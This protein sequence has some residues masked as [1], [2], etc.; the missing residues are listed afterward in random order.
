MKKIYISPSDQTKNEYAAGGTT[1]AVQCREIA[2]LLAHSLE[3][4][5]FDAKT[6]IKDG[7]AARVK[8]S[9]DFGADLHVCIHTNAYD[10]KPGE[11]E[12]SGTRLFCYSIG[13]AGYK[14]CQAVMARLA[15]VTPG[16]SD[17][18]SARPE[19]Y[20]VRVPSAPTVYVEV[21]FHD[22]PD[23]ADWILAHKADIAEA[24]AH[25]VCDYY[26]VA[27]KAPATAQTP[28]APPDPSD[29]LYRVQIGAYAVKSNA[30]AQLAKAKAAGF[31]DAFIVEV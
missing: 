23:V 13:G 16:T 14:A 18:I 25:G 19:L 20:E 10:E 15:P 9:E 3:R 24:I 29:K 31:A 30:E 12:V 22:V 4:L 28:A 21:D 2:V 11:K 1:E 17:G 6:N 5:G 7:M 26:G 27:Y 8:E